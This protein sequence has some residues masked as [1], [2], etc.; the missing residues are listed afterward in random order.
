MTEFDFNIWYRKIIDQVITLLNQGISE[1]DILNT[2]PICKKTLDI[3][4]K[5]NS[6]RVKTPVSIEPSPMSQEEEMQIK[7]IMDEFDKYEI[8]I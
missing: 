1:N 4:I 3:I 5:Q 8:L 6:C 7:A 2:L